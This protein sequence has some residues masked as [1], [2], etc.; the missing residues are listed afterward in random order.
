M[1]ELGPILLKAGTDADRQA[2]IQGTREL[3]FT[4]DKEELWV[5]NSG[6]FVKGGDADKL[7][8][9]TVAAERL[10]LDFDARRFGTL[11]AWY[12]AGRIT[13]ADRTRLA[14]LP[15]LSGN[16][17]TATSAAGLEPRYHA[18]GDFR[19]PQL[20]LGVS[21]ED[22]AIDLPASLT[23][24]SRSFSMIFVGRLQQSVFLAIIGH[25]G[26]YAG[27]AGTGAA[28]LFVKQSTLVVNS[29]TT[30]ASGYEVDS[31]LAAHSDFGVIAMTGSATELRIFDNLGNSTAF[32]ALPLSTLVGGRIG[33][34]QFGAWGKC[35]LLDFAVYSEPL[36][37]A[38]M[39][40]LRARAHETY[41]TATMAPAH[42][43]VTV[44][45][46]ITRG[47]GTNHNAWPRRLAQR[48][49][50]LR[51]YKHA[52]DGAKYA[53]VPARPPTL[54]GES[55][56]RRTIVRMI[57]TNNIALD[58]PVAASAAILYAA[59][60]ADCA[61]DRTAGYETIVVPILK[62][63]QDGDFWN[64]A[65]ETERAALAQLLRDNWPTFA[66]GFVDT[67]SDPRLD[68][69][70]TPSSFRSDGLHLNAAGAGILAELVAETLNS[71]R[72][73][74]AAGNLKLAR[75]ITA[76]GVVGAQTIH[77]PLGTVNIAAGATS[78]TVASAITT[79]ASV[80]LPVI[81]TNDATAKVKNIVPANGSF[82]IN[83]E[84]AATGETSVG[85]LVLN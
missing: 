82:T 35:E 43:V 3:H 17:H 23:V 83:L 65:K 5:G 13:A 9:G 30:G 45:D 63:V 34:S 75:K 21:E 79:T 1:P 12:S 68:P 33:K 2:T 80:V 48:L 84:A 25:L 18:T 56:A 54:G 60:Q 57:G 67:E 53:Q 49:G 15:D 24:S 58:G 6:P 37:L 47:F 74:R 73:L 22:T 26:Q 7:T 66:D 28:E 44:G 50:N 14:S 20:N 38:T 85:F 61:A 70:V 39:A 32:P 10:P 46:S 8:T 42:L 81:R 78:V 16:G 4:L 11:A 27:P 72:A 36:S 29:Q 69:V 41:D 19:H 76:A 31:L 77:A 40:R 52:F 55:F 51:L 71:V 62:R 64:A 59:I